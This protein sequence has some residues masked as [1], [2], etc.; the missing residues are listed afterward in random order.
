VLA[1]STLPAYSQQ[2]AG[3][4]QTPKAGQPK[5]APAKQVPAKQTS[6]KQSASKSVPGKAVQAKGV[7]PKTSPVHTAV[8]RRPAA[9]RYYYQTQPTPD[10]YKEIQQALADRGYFSASPDGTWGASSVDALKR[11][12]HDQNLAEEGKIDALSLTALGLGPK[13]ST[14]TAATPPQAP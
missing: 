2:K 6:A 10:R 3:A 4:K 12:Q 13:R 1:A 14:T 5:Q 11:F 8:V 9:P 7:P